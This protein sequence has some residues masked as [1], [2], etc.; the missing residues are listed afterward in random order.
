MYT[1]IL[2]P[3]ALDHEGG[4]GPAIAAAKCLKDAAGSVELLHVLEEVPGFVA[5]ELPSGILDRNR[6][7][8][9]AALGRVA[10]SSGL[11]P[12]VTVVTGH[13]S[14]SILDHAEATGADCIVIVSH[15]PG[16]QDYFLGSTA[17][18]VVRHAPC[19]VHVIR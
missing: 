1:S 19:A 16:L 13:A 9:E 3:V 17:A 14:R 12:K 8:A 11:S 5:A 2:V 18:R 6:A 4:W 10:A 7:E 15:R